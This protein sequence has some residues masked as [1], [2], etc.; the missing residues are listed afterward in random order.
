MKASYVKLHTAFISIAFAVCT[1]FF[2]PAASACNSIG[3]TNFNY[4]DRGQQFGNFGMLIAHQNDGNVVV[5]SN[6]R[7]VWATGTNGRATTR[8]VF[9][10]DGNLVLF[11]PNGVVWNS[12][13][14]VSSNNF[15]GIT[16]PCGNIPGTVGI[17]NFYFTNRVYYSFFFSRFW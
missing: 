8:L 7:G 5:Y 15:F 3:M 4:L 10:G 14:A 16:Q 2:A 9:Q 12:G 1:M 17:G 11:G 13:T 6:G